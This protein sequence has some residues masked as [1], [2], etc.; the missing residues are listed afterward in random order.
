M[1]DI[2]KRIPNCQNFRQ[3][4]FPDDG[5]GVGGVGLLIAQF[6]V[7]SPRGSLEVSC[8]GPESSFFLQ[9]SRFV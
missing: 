6:R 5:R 2:L 4:V 8:A 3:R 9:S 1:R 7:D